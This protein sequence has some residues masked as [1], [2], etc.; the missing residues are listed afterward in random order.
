MGAGSL[1]LLLLLQQLVSASQ[2]S[3][4]QPSN[5][6]RGITNSFGVF[7]AHYTS[8]NPPLSDVSS[9]AWVGSTQAFLLLFIA[10]ICGRL[11]DAGYARLLIRVGTVLI[12]AGILCT[13]YA[14]TFLPTIFAQGILTGLGLGMLFTPSM[15]I[16]PP[17]FREGRRRATAVGL[18]VSG[19]GLGGVVYP[20]LVRKA[21]ARYGFGWSQRAMLLV[22]L[23]TQTLPCA[24][25]CQRSGIPTRSFRSGS[26]VDLP[27]LR[28]VRFV[29]FCAGAFF[30]ILGLFEP[31][32]F[33]EIWAKSVPVKLGFEPYYLVSVMNAGGTLGR[34]FPCLIA[35][36]V[37][38]SSLPAPRY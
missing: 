9:I 19:S 28:N 13:S 29:V 24:L 12:V 21:M 18:A 11:C 27:A 35:G 36:Y 5:I 7:Q 16:L 3:H 32:F 2:P 10:P 30:T 37:P 38:S 8:I 6:S 25:V 15:A 4:E 14:K 23:A 34:V 33:L 22:V 20:I 31:Y 17:Y 1:R 26:L